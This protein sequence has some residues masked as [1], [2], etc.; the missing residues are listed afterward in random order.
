MRTR[1]GGAFADLS[2]TEAL[3]LLRC[4]NEAKDNVLE[5]RAFDFDARHDGVLVTKHSQTNSASTV[6][7]DSTSY[8]GVAV[9]AGDYVWRIVVTND[10]AT[11]P[12]Q[13]STAYR[14]VSLNP[15]TGVGTLDSAYLGATQPGTAEILMYVS[16]YKLPDTVRDV[17]S[18]R[19]QHQDVRLIQVP[20]DE[21][22]F[23]V[24]TRHH[25]Q[26][27][28]TPDLVA[29][30]SQVTPTYDSR[31]SSVAPGL[32]LLV[33]PAPLNGYRLDYSYLYRHPQ[34]SASQ[35]LE[36]VPDNVVHDIILKAFAYYEQSTGKDPDLAAASNNLSEVRI[37]QVYN[38]NAPDPLRHRPLRSLDD[39][40]GGVVIGSRPANPDVFE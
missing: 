27:T 24:V 9:T 31:G 20:R 39:R 34:L 37:S 19:F 29:V 3:T 12:N 11:V 21:S 33:Y 30:G 36:N 1:G 35:D 16:E 2:S 7:N 38:Q 10:S 15:V 5:T 13:A 8:T 28:D 25:D 23:S 32:G 26:M 14:I 4:V 6:A 18:V 22:F 40:T 17:L